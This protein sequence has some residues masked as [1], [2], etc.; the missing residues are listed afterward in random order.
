MLAIVGLPR[1]VGQVFDDIAAWGGVFAG[2]AEATR[3]IGEALGGVV[4]GPVGQWAVVIASTIFVVWVNLGRRDAKAGLTPPT[5]ETSSAT[6]PDQEP[7]P[8]LN[9]LLIQDAIAED[10]ID[11][12]ASMADDMPFHEAMEIEGYPTERIAQMAEEQATDPPEDWSGAFWK[13]K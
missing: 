3:A 6:M 7:G 2:V 1:Q 13:G 5:R 10:A 11:R 4:A 8:S 9:D 12:A